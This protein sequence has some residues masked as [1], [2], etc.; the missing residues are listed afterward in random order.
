MQLDGKMPNIALM[1]ISTYHKRLGDDVDWYEPFFDQ[2]TDILYI[3]KLFD[4]TEDIKYLPFNA[5]VIKGGTGYDVNSKLPEEIEIIN[6]LDYSLYPDCKFSVQFYSRGCVKKCAFCVVPEKEGRI[7]S[8]KP[9]NL[10]PRGTYIEVL[11]NNFFANPKWEE[12]INDLIDT[13]QAVHFN[14]VQLETLNEKKCAYINKLKLHKAIKI[15]W[16][17]PKDDPRDK[18]KDVLKHLRYYK[19]MCYVL[20]GFNSTK[21]EDLYRVLELDKLKIDPFVMP[22]NKKDPYQKAFARWVNDK[23]TFNKCAWKDYKYNLGY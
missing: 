14:G 2:D 12:A 10:N 13:N 23:A 3:A 21:E 9:Y 5:K 22:Y 16:D 4:F 6:E 11:D 1:K 19:L 7:K 17:D 18:I 15:A 20:I 8:V